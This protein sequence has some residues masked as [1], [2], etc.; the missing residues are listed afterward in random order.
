MQHAVPHTPPSIH[1]ATTK[2]RWQHNYMALHTRSG[3]YS[4]YLHTVSC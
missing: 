2:P 3:R 1:T 4:L